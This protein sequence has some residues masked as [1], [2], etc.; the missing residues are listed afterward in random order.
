MRLPGH[1]LADPE[2]HTTPAVTSEG[3]IRHTQIPAVE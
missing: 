1:H 2:E 3:K